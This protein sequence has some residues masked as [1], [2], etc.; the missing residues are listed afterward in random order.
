L[1]ARAS[2]NCSV[3]SVVPPN[4]PLTRRR[5]VAFIDADAYFVTDPGRLLDL[6]CEHGFTAWQEGDNVKWPRCGFPEGKPPAAPDGIQGGQFALDRVRVWRELLLAHWICQH[7]DYYWPNGKPAGEWTLLGDQDAWPLAFAL[8]PPSAI[9][10]K[11][12][13]FVRKVQTLRRAADR[14]S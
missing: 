7:S 14:Q 4:G 1:I 12:T 11:L 5:Y 3:S 10:V 2:R 13:G 6:A 8:K 9:K